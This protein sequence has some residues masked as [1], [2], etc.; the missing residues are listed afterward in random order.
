MVAITSGV[1]SSLFSDFGTNHI[2]TDANGEP[3][4]TVALTNIEVFEKPPTLGVQ[5]VADGEPIVVM[6]CASMHGL[7]DGDIIEL[8]DM[9]GDMEGLTGKRQGETE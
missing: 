7:Y 4:D 1:T 9:H 2:I 6:S 3:L 5:G 8:D